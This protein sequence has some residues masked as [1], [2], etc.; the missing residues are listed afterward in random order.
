M[1]V[2]LRGARTSDPQ[3]SP[4]DG[5]R[6][7]GSGFPHRPGQ[8]GFR[9][10]VEGL[11]AVAVGAVLLFHAGLPF[12]PGGF[13]GV[14]VFFVI[15]GYLITGLLVGEL[16]ATG[17]VSLPRFYARRARRLLPMAAVVLG[18][19]AVASWLVQPPVRRVEVADDVVASALYAVNWRL[20]ERAV[21]YFASGGFDSPVQ[22]FWS[23]AVEEQFYL[24]WPALL[25]VLAWWARWRAVGLR[26][27]VLPAVVAAGG[28]SLAY[29]LL[30]TYVETG[31]AYF[32]SFTRGWELALG[33][34]LALA[35][36]GRR[37]L[38]VPMAGA[39]AWGGLAAIGYAVVAFDA[40]TRFPGAAALVPTVGVAAVI[41]AGASSVQHGAGRLLTSRG[42]RHVGR[43]SYAWYLWHW[44]V[45]V[46]AGEVFGALSAVEGFVF[47]AA[48]WVPAVVT[49]HLVEQP[50]RRSS[51]LSA[52]TRRAL[53]LGLVCTLTAALSGVWLSWTAP[54][55]PEAPQNEVRGAE[56]A[57][58]STPDNPHQ[59]SVSALRPEPSRAD[60]DR[61]RM[62]DDG[63]LVSPGGTR[64]PRCVYGDTS[65]DITAVMF[66][67]SHMMQ[68]FPAV[69]AI[70][71]RRGWRLVGL[72]KAGCPAADVTPFTG[73]FDRE[74]DE[75]LEWREHTLR[76]I[77][78]TEEP[79]LILTS[80]L[81]RYSVVVDGQRLDRTASAG[82]LE[83]GYVRTLRHLREATGAKIAVIR[84][85]PRL[86]DVPACVSAHL[87]D[88]ASCAEREDS[89][90]GARSVNVGAA[91]RVDGAQVIDP[92]PLMCPDGICPGVMGNALVYRDDGHLSATYVKTLTQWLDEQV[93][94]VPAPDTS[95]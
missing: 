53:Q 2:A 48:S 95:D 21:D 54:Q 35:L 74:Y 41:V 11:R 84:D 16:S 19:V 5:T 69:E 50:F 22:H 17:S 67:D 37:R 25:L 79:D 34:V 80:G 12:T 26:R 66:G 73:I 14:D 85:N 32:S 83:D 8:T 10:D 64:S 86:L 42:M 3:T 59:Q 75:C 56:A 15:S 20:S 38:P 47:A 18:S 33:G 63:C 7:G 44:P 70:A 60:E 29:C 46:F 72:T 57:R 13:V 30:R 51:M 36:T 89:V 88:L 78:R 82:Y 65:S 1:D 58:P 9:P 43:V 39:L 28:V 52:H 49:H 71:N 94:E 81:E 4:T 90:L 68:Y 93:P 77:V 45:L 6:P 55:V 76:R 62:A 61:S 92:T 87:D 27:V 40:S 23:L 31:E 24:A 91:G